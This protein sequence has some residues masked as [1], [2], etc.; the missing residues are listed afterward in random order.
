MQTG[1]QLLLCEQNHVVDGASAKSSSKSITSVWGGM[2]YD[3]STT[4]IG[5]G[6]AGLSGTA[7]ILCRPDSTE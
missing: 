6:R 7:C 5:I 3:A 4:S 2:Q 1:P